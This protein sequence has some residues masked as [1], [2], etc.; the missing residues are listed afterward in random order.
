MKIGDFVIYEGMGARED[1]IGKII[2][3]H[4][5]PQGGCMLD[6]FYFSDNGTI[7]SAPAHKVRPATPMDVLISDVEIFVEDY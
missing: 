6:I 3:I 7:Y 5:L 4:K 1:W 2:S